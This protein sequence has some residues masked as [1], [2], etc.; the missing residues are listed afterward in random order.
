MRSVTCTFG[1][2][3]PPVRVDQLLNSLDIVDLARQQDFA[4]V[5]QRDQAAVEH[6][7]DG[8]R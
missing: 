4:R 1:Q 7:V 3:R 5:A 8:A 6:P 2:A